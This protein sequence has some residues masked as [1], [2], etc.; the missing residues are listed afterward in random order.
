LGLSA[1]DFQTAIELLKK[2]SVS[3]R[4]GWREITAILTGLGMSSA[5]IWMVLAAIVDPEPTTKL[6]ILTFGGVMLVLTG[7]LSILRA[8]GQPWRV[9]AIRGSRAISVEPR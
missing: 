5:G 3:R 8:L 4:T 7:G 2:M 1:D 9:T 6:W